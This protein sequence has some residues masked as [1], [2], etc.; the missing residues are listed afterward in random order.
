VNYNKKFNFT[1]DRKTIQRTLK[2]CICHVSPPYKSFRLMKLP[3]LMVLFKLTI[4]KISKYRLTKIFNK[5]E[6]NQ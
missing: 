4:L 1:I 6:A 3:M 2:K 5:L